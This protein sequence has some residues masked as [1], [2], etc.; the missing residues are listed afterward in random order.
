MHIVWNDIDLEL[1]S[2]PVWPTTRAFVETVI[3]R[4]DDGTYWVKD[5]GVVD[6]QGNGPLERAEGLADSR[7]ATIR[8]TFAIRRQRSICVDVRRGMELRMRRQDGGEAV[9][10]SAQNS[11]STQVAATETVPPSQ[12]DER[13]SSR[14]SGR[15]R[16]SDT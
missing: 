9:T 2:R 14:L 7:D 13:T 4:F 3:A 1:A 15:P 11:P 8:L 5:E 16:R 12:R 10:C 6:G